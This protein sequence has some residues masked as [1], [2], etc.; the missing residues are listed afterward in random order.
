MLEQLLGEIASLTKKD[1][2][3]VIANLKGENGDWLADA[4]TKLKGELVEHIKTI[5]EQQYSR[6]IKE[7]GTKF[8]KIAKE[9]LADLFKLEDFSDEDGLI[10]A[11]AEQARGMKQ[12]EGGKTLE[13]L[14]KTPDAKRYISDQIENA[15]AKKLTEYQTKEAQMKAELVQYQQQAKKARLQSEV[16]TRAEKLGIAVRVEGNEELTSKRVQTMLHLLSGY[17]YDDNLNPIDQDGNPVYD[18]HTKLDFEGLV[19]KVN[20]FEPIQS[21]AAGGFPPNGQGGGSK[22]RFSS[23]ED[24]MKAREQENDPKVRQEM[25]KAWLAQQAGK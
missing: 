24:F 1:A 23:A 8:G 6:G 19:S 9:K 4:P 20:P 13:E 5:A 11:I 10:S 15:T 21:K 14:L 2:S 17:N 3:E 16:L 18:G 22:Y 7:K 12:T 25:G